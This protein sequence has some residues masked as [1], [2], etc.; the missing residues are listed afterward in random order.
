MNVMP[1]V[2]RDTAALIPPKARVGLII[3]GT[4]SPSTAVATRTSTTSASTSAVS[5][6]PA[7]STW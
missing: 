6:A 7:S 3:P 4:R 2:N 1:N 5:R